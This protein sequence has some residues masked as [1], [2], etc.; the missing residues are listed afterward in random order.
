MFAHAG[1]DDADASPDLRT[2]AS[3]DDP[4]AVRRYRQLL[5]VGVGRD[6]E[7][8]FLEAHPSALAWAQQALGNAYVAAL[9]EPAAAPGSGGDAGAG[10][11]VANEAEA[12]AQL[13][14]IV[15][16]L[17]GKYDTAKT[18][19]LG[20]RTQNRWLQD[21]FIDRYYIVRPD[22]NVAAFLCTTMP[23]MKGSNPG[24]AP[25]L[26]PGNYTAA[27]EGNHAYG[28]VYR[29][30]ADDAH[31]R[32][33]D[34]TLPARRDANHDG[35]FSDAELGKPRTAD[36]ILQHRGNTSDKN[37][38]VK[39]GPDG[40]PTTFHTPGLYSEG[41]MNVPKQDNDAFADFVGGSGYEYTL[42]EQQQLPMA[43]PDV[44]F[45]NA[46]VSDYGVMV[47]AQE[48]Y[49]QWLAANPDFAPGG[50]FGP[51]SGVMP[52][53]ATLSPDE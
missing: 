48:R 17:G 16:A 7:R 1:R 33:G 44:P 26:A 3:T 49:A 6:E 20:V 30:F 39:P 10:R 29:L 36:G 11:G 50:R 13:R 8:A 2:E 46:S 28:R 27:Y 41:C 53:D 22:G 24:G 43:L 23:N 4:E 35:E 9:M 52:A 21:D 37:L 5:V 15:R 51:G 34:G 25:Q 19:V 38:G 45:A 42:V 18:L 31:R 14:A 32:R 40:A 47:S 12:A